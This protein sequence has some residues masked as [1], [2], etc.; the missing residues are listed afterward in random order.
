M[1]TQRLVLAILALLA[2]TAALAH[3]GVGPINSFWAGLAHPLLGADHLL[4]MVAV[5]LW[6]ALAAPRLFWVAP[7]GF[8]AGILGGGFLGMTGLAFPGIEVMI[9][10][11]VVVFGALAL[12]K[13]Q[14]PAVLAFSVA[15]IFGGA[16]GFAHGAEMPLG[17]GALQYAAGFLIATATLHALGAATGLTVK[18]FNLVRLGQAAGGAVAAAGVILTVL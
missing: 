5:G 12:F 11:S 3:T 13:I 10:G 18:H 7:A 14:A 9:A 8:L 6:A 1:F 16:H 2:P 17:G 4:A 15:A